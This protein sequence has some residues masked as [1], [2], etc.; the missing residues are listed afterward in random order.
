MAV[1]KKKKAAK[2]STPKTDA[3]EEKPQLTGD[4]LLD[5]AGKAVKDEAKT[6]P[7]YKN[8][9]SVVEATPTGRPARVIIKCQDPQVDGD[10]NSVCDKEREI[11]IQD[12]HQV[13]RCVSCQKR[14]VQVYRNELARKR[15]AA[16]AGGK[17]A[18][19][20][21]AKP[22]KAKKQKKAK[23]VKKTKKAAAE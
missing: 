14:H 13:T 17:P 16:K 7:A 20:K 10:G 23:K 21:A 3:A 5:M 6:N 22:A 12:L 4:E 1:K 18:K 9:T 2:K 15:R 8:I 11:A 19:E